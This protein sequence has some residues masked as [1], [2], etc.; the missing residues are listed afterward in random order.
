MVQHKLMIPYEIQ[1]DLVPTD[2]D[3]VEYNKFVSYCKPLI[4]S[5]HIILCYL[6]NVELGFGNWQKIRMSHSTVAFN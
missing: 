2:D 6:A 5:P 3:T 1:N 4:P